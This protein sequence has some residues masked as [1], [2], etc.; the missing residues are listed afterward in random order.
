MLLH[1]YGYSTLDM[2]MAS[3]E[4]IHFGWYQHTANDKRH[5]RY[6]LICYKICP[7]TLRYGNVGK[8]GVN[9]CFQRTAAQHIGHRNLRLVT[10]WTYN[11]E[12]IRRHLRCD[13]LTFTQICGTWDIICWYGQ[14]VPTAT[15]WLGDESMRTISQMASTNKTWFF[16]HIIT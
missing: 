2:C 11:A 6:I 5:F 13:W 15:L 10:L 8:L 14:I 4:N 16:R 7:K 1:K 9:N 12:M 3:T